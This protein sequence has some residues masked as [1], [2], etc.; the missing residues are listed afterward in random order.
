M[1]R[2]TLLKLFEDQGWT[3][4][5]TVVERSAVAGVGVAMSS[6]G[7]P[8][9]LPLENLIEIKEH[10]LVFEY[11]YKATPIGLLAGHTSGTTRI[12]APWSSISYVYKNQP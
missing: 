4:N 12:W 6:G 10:F 8:H 11:E 2:S 1:E 3:R 5:G 7:Q 9:F